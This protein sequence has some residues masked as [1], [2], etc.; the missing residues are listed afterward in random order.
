[1]NIHKDYAGISTRLLGVALG[2]GALAA[3]TGCGGAGSSTTVTSKPIAA[4]ARQALHGKVHGGQQ[5]IS[6]AYVQLFAIGTT[7]AKSASTFLTGAGTD[8]NG[9]FNLTGSYTCP[10]QGSLVYITSMGGNPGISA[11]T[12]NAA[13]GLMAAIGPCNYPNVDSSGNITYTLDP[14]SFIQINEVT[15]IASV[16]ALAPFMADYMDIGSSG[17]LL[18]ITDAFSTAAMLA[19]VSAGSS[20]GPALPASVTYDPST[21]FPVIINTLAN[22][23]ASC[24]NSDGT[25]QPC[26]FLFSITTIGN[27]V[28][29]DTIAAS[30]VIATHPGTSPQGLISL[31]TPDAPFAP[32]L[33][34]IPNDWTVS[35]HYTGLGL[36]A[37]SGL[38][39]DSQS[40]LWTTNQAS[41]SITKV[42]S[43]IDGVNAPGSSV[44][45]TGGGILGA[46]AIAIDQT[47]DVWIANTAGNSVVELDGN[48]NVLSGAGYTA[49]GI[50]APVSIA[51][52]TKGNAWVA[53]YNGNSITQLLS[54]GTASSFSPITQG[55]SN[56]AVSQPTAI[57]IDGTNQVWVTNSGLQAQGGYNGLA[58]QVLLFNQN[59]APENLLPQ[60]IQNPLGLAV[61]ASNNVWIASSGTS[62]V[63][64]YND[65]PGY[66]TVGDT[67]TGGGLAQPAGVAVDGAGNIWVTNDGTTGSLSEIAANGTVLSPASGFGALNAPSGV[68]VDASGNL[69]TANAGDNSVTQ[70]VGLGTPAVTPVIAGLMSMKRGPIAAKARGTSH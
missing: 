38:A 33:S 67:V 6:G 25:G 47:G 11:N 16:Y 54:N 30:L 39:F 29:A 7:G 43:G 13:A 62:L 42:Y 26:G 68:A 34:T 3:L 27:T 12:N 21:G 63:Q 23:I 46:R 28:P 48:G 61:D 2:M 4:A 60:G 56:Y 49:G 5:P 64:A 14:N 20:P 44:Q 35:L 50:N 22:A 65:G 53:N 8:Q 58:S 10:Q 15:T 69:W 18:G 52:D 57:A 55:Y 36:G 37:P 17:N 51:I 19:D 45:V 31:V 40:N 41:N 9:D 1:M 66:I 59:G 32:T 24:I 70:F